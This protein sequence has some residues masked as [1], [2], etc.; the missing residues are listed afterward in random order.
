MGDFSR[1][2]SHW[3]PAAQVHFLPWHID[4]LYL[5]LLI[6]RGLL[7]L[8]LAGLALAA[9]LRRGIYAGGAG[10]QTSQLS[11]AL[12]AGVAGGLLVGIWGS[13]MDVPRVAFLLFL[14]I[15]CL[16]EWPRGTDLR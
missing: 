7:G 3:F 4:N 15:T 16:I 14:L 10:G 12:A 13:V 2:L 8:L 11:D 1:G 5:E 9:A 6:E